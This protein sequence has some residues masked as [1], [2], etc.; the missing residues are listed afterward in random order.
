MRAVYTGCN[1]ISTPIKL[2]PNESSPQQ[3]RVP[4]QRPVAH[5]Q[6]PSESGG[7]CSVVVAAVSGVAVGG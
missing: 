1:L 3:Q 4:Q 6:Q 2:F 5:A 7:G